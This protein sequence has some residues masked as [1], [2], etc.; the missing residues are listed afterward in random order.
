MLNETLS[1]N[2]MSKPPG[3]CICLDEFISPASLPCGHCFCLECIGE[4]WRISES[5]QCPL[6]MVVFP[7]RPQLKTIQT[8]QTENEIELLKAGEVP[9]NVCLAKRPAVRSCLVC[10]ASYCTTH[11]EPHYKREDLGCHL[12]VSVAKNLEDSLCGLHGRKL[13]RFCRSDRTCIC[14]MCA[15]TEHRGH[16]I[17]SISREAAKNKIKLKRRRIKIQQEIQDKLS[18]AE[19]M[20]LTADLHGELSADLWAQTTKLIKQL[21]E[22]ISELQKRN[23]ELEQFSKTEDNLHF[24]QRFLHSYS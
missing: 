15:K 14:T 13:E 22:E 7:K 11:L 1:S 24:L 3:C 10:L 23:A 4:Y 9:C 8:P 16:H 17:V 2:L 19:E 20:K 12:L 6:C 18:A 21:E 5:C